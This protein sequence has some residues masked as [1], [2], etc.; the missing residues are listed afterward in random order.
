MASADQNEPEG[1]YIVVMRSSDDLD[2]EEAEISRSGGRTEKRFS[3][4]INALSVKV[5]HSEAARIRNNP[6]VLL[7]E[8]DQPM[9]ALDTQNPSPS[10]G[11]DRIDQRSLPLNST[12]TASA[13]GANVDVYI[14]DTGIYAAHT[15]FTGRLGAGF[16]AINDGNG[17]NDCN[18]HG[19]H[20]AGT[21]AGTTYGIAKS[22]TLIPVRVLGCTGSGTT[23]GVIAGLD[24]IVGHHIA[25]T[26]A[27]ANMS[28]GGGASAALDT[29][30]QNVINDGVVMA[31]AAG[32]DGLNACNYSP[33]RAAN[34]I[35]VGSTTSTDARSTFSN[36]GT[37]VDI[38]APGSSITSSWIGSST[39][40]TSISGTSMASPHVAGVAAVLLG[41]YPT[42]T[43]TEIA[44]MLRT[45]A[46][47]NVVTS[48]GTGSPNFLLYLD[49]LGGPIVA[50]PPPTPVAPSA[51][52]GIIITPS[53]G[54]LSVAFTAGSAGT[55]PITTYKYSV[56]GG[57]NWA[58]RQT[59]TTASPIVITGLTNGNT[60][61]V[62]I[63]AV[64][65]VGDGAA[66]TAVSA[67]IPTPVAPSAP[68]G[69]IITPSSGR[70][71]VAFTAG[72]AGTSP[73]T[74]YKYSV[75]G[76]TNWATRQT[77]TTASP[78]V[79]TGLTN[80][81]SYLVS[82]R[83]VSLAGDGAASTA[84]SATI[85][86]APATPT[87]GT[88]TANAGRTAT[89]RWTLG[90]NGGSA[91]TSHIVTAYLNGS[92][93]VARSVTVNGATSVSATVTGLTAGGSYTFR[94]QARN[95]F[96]NSALSLSSN[97]VIARR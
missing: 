77:G 29:A 45:S 20:V 34:A 60:Y 57:T 4:A 95:A 31:V 54:R 65:L 85:P 52:T 62:S 18:G 25:G 63:R 46:T 42:S 58:T 35:T 92:A 84:V 37:C 28:L 68:T 79:I 61:L 2:S 40:I 17:T 76:G 59:G 67:T 48:A 55:S 73:I 88:A 90:A 3:R 33:A 30:V 87:I 12:F 53:S 50:P 10:W 38:F 75:D 91:I 97:A 71:S 81:S 8:L 94:V 36:T 39:A 15:D 43:T 80:G 86:T 9:Y 13:K 7:V 21:S 74:T 56:D 22:A 1:S 14:V 78:I 32:N 66:S 49:P 11:L 93:T 19:T 89:V 51:P 27:V 47:P 83:A 82:I 64:S 16:T 44:S 26:P 5:K 6:K 41:R 70:L 72:S 69:I 24:W 96:G 23:A